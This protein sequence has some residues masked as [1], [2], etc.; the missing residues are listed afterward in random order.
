MLGDRVQLLGRGAGVMM[1]VGTG[2]AGPAGSRA[3]SP[4]AGWKEASS[5]LWWQLV[6]KS[7]PLRASAPCIYMPEP[8]DF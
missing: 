7:G 4:G 5:E 3:R 6:D 1:C 8:I 2:A